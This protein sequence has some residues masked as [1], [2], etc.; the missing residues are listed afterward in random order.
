MNDKTK[1][2]FEKIKEQIEKLSPAVRK[3]IVTVGI[4]VL[5]LSLGTTLYLNTRPYEDLFSGLTNEEAVDV[6]TQLQEKGVSYKFDNGTI[7]VPKSVVEELKMQLAMEGYPKGGFTYDT[8]TNN[9]SMMSTDFENQTYKIYEL[10]DRIAATI[11]SYSGVKDAR[12]TIS[13]IEDNKYVLNTQ[14]VQTATASVSVTMND[15]GSP[16]ED[17]VRG[18]QSLVSKSI[19][20]ATME[21]VGVYDGVGRDVTIVQEDSVT[22]ANKIKLDLEKYFDDNIRTKI[23]NVLSP[24]YGADNITISV[25]SEVDIDKRISEIINH[26]APIVASETSGVEFSRNPDAE[27]GVPGTEN[28]AEIPTYGNIAVDGTENYYAGQESIDYYVNQLKEQVQSDAGN[29][30]DLRISVA[31]NGED[32]GNL[33][34]ADLVSLIGNAAGIANAE[35]VDKIAIVATPFF[36]PEELEEVLEDNQWILIGAAAAALFLLLMIIFIIILRK[37]KKKKKKK[38]EEEVVGDDGMVMPSAGPVDHSRLEEEYLKRMLEK[39]QLDVE[40]KLMSLNSEAANELKS[41]ISEFA[42]DSP[43]ISAQLI[44]KWLNGDGR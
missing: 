38:G 7:T 30:T 24:I 42:E 9:V 33:E 11:R 3:L 5:V 19:P 14:S 25:I 18:I 37:K 21:S 2:F 40:A 31:I 39:Q 23:L 44:K 12:V 4:G 20:N 17:L 22:A 34:Y 13:V 41:K 26:S 32:F 15:G 27:G 35:Q 29:L 1:E 6:M 10:Q 8:F 28:N 16:S 43:E 36:T